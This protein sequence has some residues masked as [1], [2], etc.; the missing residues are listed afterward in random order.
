MPA[1]LAAV[2]AQS[3]ASLLRALLAR[4]CGLVSLATPVDHL[5]ESYGEANA[6]VHART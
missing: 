6:I 1:L 5:I 2:R 4:A 3:L